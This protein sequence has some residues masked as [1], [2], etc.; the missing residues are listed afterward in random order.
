MASSV[1]NSASKAV[2]A[3]AAPVAAMAAPTV[4]K[5]LRRLSLMNPIIISAIAWAVAC[6][7]YAV[8]Q[9]PE[10]PLTSPELLKEQLQRRIKSI[11]V[12]PESPR[13]QQ[14]KQYYQHQHDQQMAE[15]KIHLAQWQR[16]NTQFN[17]RILLQGLGVGVMILAAVLACLEYHYGAISFWMEATEELWCDA[18]DRWQKSQAKRRQL[19]DSQKMERLLQEM[20]EGQEDQAAKGVVKRERKKVQQPSVA[21]NASVPSKPAGEGRPKA[22]VPVTA[23]A[24]PAAEACS[25]PI[26]PRPADA[27]TASSAGLP[28]PG[29]GTFGT[30][31]EKSR[32][33]T[34]AANGAG[35]AKPGSDTPETKSEKPRADAGHAQQM[36]PQAVQAMPL[37][38]SDSTL[39]AEAW[40]N[41]QAWPCDASLGSNVRDRLRRKVIERQLN[42]AGASESNKAEAQS[43]C[44]D[45]ETSLA[46]GGASKKPKKDS[47]VQQKAK[48][49]KPEVQKSHV[50]SDA[51][52]QPKKVVETP[53]AR[54]ACKAAKSPS[55][56]APADVPEV[57][58][59]PV[60]P[61]VKAA[62]GL[63]GAA[64]LREAE[65][66]LSRLEAEDLLRELETEE[67][68]AKKAAGRKKAKK[69]K[70]K[71]S[72][73]KTSA[74]EPVELA[75]SCGL[76][77][78]QDEL[79]RPADKSTRKIDC[80]RLEQE[81]DDSEDEDEAQS[82][83]EESSGEDISMS[84]E[85][86]TDVH[87]AS[88]EHL[89]SAASLAEEEEILAEPAAPR[90]HKKTI[91]S[92]DEEPTPSQAS[93]GVP[94][95]PA[96]SLSQRTG[97]MLSKAGVNLRSTSWADVHDEVAPAAQAVQ[98]KVTS[99][100]VK[101]KAARAVK[102]AAGMQRAAKPE[103]IQCQRQAQQAYQAKPQHV[104]ILAPP[105][106]TQAPAPPAERPR[107]SNYAE[108]ASGNRQHS[109]TS[110]LL[111]AIG[112]C[113]RD[114]IV[115]FIYTNSTEEWRKKHIPS[116]IQTCTV[117]ELQRIAEDLLQGLMQDRD[118]S[119]KAKSNGDNFDGARAG[120]Q[121]LEWVNG[122]LGTQ[123]AIN[124]SSTPSRQRRRQRNR[125][126]WI[127]SST[128]PEV[129]AE[130]GEDAPVDDKEDDDMSSWTLR[131][132]APEFVPSENIE[133]TPEM[134]PESMPQAAPTA[135]ALPPGWTLRAEAPEFVPSE[136]IEN[137]PEMA[138][139]SMPQ[140]APTAFALPPG[141]QIVMVPVQLPQAMYE[142]NQPVPMQDIPV[143]AVVIKSQVAVGDHCSRKYEQH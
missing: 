120:A 139:E 76:K 71:G 55:A 36:P 101:A 29:S 99:V 5:Q 138:P 18:R 13:Y 45:P 108:A 107:P 7:G 20:G 104:R 11:P 136:N 72:C 75:S 40:Q 80:I 15:Y 114:D 23:S 26:L 96:E 128:E 126:Q 134:A 22:L 117:Q 17:W 34:C 39:P 92:S 122:G 98:Q 25:Q 113:T 87:S 16:S 89:S 62:E 83:A 118:D 9:V 6:V 53:V 133:N 124:Q 85:D 56:K 28:K 127:Q 12:P 47:E 38:K 125:Q 102:P 110:S 52:S 93:T 57:V 109:E 14:Y 21:E 94:S 68:R 2:A 3:A 141:C 115:E 51:Q 69:N 84:E 140:A 33:D 106:R 42:S 90:K 129:H 27:C 10:A 54:S 81:E 91:A 30:K 111:N 97:D 8:W 82:Q 63:R 59:A 61:A 88:N 79:V 67:E 48:M 73:A 137:T 112:V 58:A 103:A 49:Q 143:K 50:P 121:I 44:E 60:A 86:S 135:F 46:A 43:P 119:S 132:E 130:N 116:D 1:P 77:K 70:A 37:P 41:V 24:S 65:E 31:S 131:A 32:A 74:P 35:L 66:L 142:A 105:P 95:S 100:D 19:A 78:T 64:L 123:D 4:P